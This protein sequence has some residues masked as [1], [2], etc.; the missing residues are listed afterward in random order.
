MT[1]NTKQVLSAIAGLLAGLA[2]QAATVNEPESWTNGTIAGWVGYDLIN[3]TTKAASDFAVDSGAL[4]LRY[5]PQSVSLP[6]DECVFKADSGASGGRFTGSYL[7]VAV[8][9]VSFKIRCDLPSPVTLLIQNDTSHRRWR[10]DLGTPVTGQ[11]VTLTAPVSPEALKLINGTQDWSTF[12]QDLANVSW[13]GV[14]VIRNPSLNL[15]FERLDDFQ[16][17][18][19]GPEFTAW[20]QG[21]SGGSAWRREL[22]PDGDLD[23]DG[24]DNFSEW[25]AGTDPNDSNTEFRVSVDIGDDGSVTVKWPSA[26]GRLYQVYRADKVEGPYAPVGAEVAATAPEN[27]YTDGTAS[28]AA[29]VFYKVT[30]RKP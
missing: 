5:L 15:Q 12:Q 20:I 14:E 27:R 24:A 13:I 28:A 19:A 29:P 1:M 21:Y 3:E 16:L 17:V 8:M 22:L 30:V 9:A 7:D 18:G 6:P 10:Y 23:K 11:W 25:I 26:A 4:K 2:C